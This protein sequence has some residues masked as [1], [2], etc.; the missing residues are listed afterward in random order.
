MCT[1]YHET[2]DEL[3][4]AFQPSPIFCVAACSLFSPP[5]LLSL[6]N[7]KYL[8]SYSINLSFNIPC[9]LITMKLS[10]AQTTISKIFTFFYNTLHTN[11]IFKITTGNTSSLIL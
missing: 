3:L 8:F 2:E 5:Y 11:P 1:D 4:N 9:V 10:L 6:D 7:R